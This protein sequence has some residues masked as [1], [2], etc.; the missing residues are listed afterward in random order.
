M[1]FFTVI[2]FLTI[3]PIYGQE[4]SAQPTSHGNH[5][6][7]PNKPPHQASSEAVTVINQQA[8]P[9]QENRSKEH[10]QSYLS[11][12]LTPE[13]LPNVGLFFVG[14]G[15]ILVAVRTL[16]K[17]D[18]Q[19]AATRDATVAA[20]TSANAANESVKAVINS[21]RAWVMLDS[22]TPHDEHI[23][24]LILQGNYPVPKLRVVFRN[25]G[26]TPAWI[27]GHGFRF[28]IEN[29]EWRPPNRYAGEIESTFGGPLPP[30][31]LPETWVPTVIEVSMEPPL[32][33]K[34]TR[35]EIQELIS[36]EKI[37]ILYGIVVYRDTFS[38]KPTLETSVCLRLVFRS[39]ED[40]TPSRWMY[41]YPEANRHT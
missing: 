31:P 12:L 15:G 29:K 23:A 24:N 41:V 14:F 17:I 8:S 34:L 22:V 10:T 27:T 4:K 26:R 40:R 36:G 1:K 25:F 5:A 35:E 9:V 21:E 39:A 32:V 3:L 13:N 38:T 18:E 2:F 16:R 6:T 19:I 30:E 33:H 7:E 11:R 37:L 28:S 20:Q